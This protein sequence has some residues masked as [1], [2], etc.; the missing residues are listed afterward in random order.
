MLAGG[1]ADKAGIKAGDILLNA[2]GKPVDNPANLQE[3]LRKT[4]GDAIELLIERSGKQ[5]SIRLA[6]G[7]PGICLRR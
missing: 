7:P 6:K 2:N 3:I 4:R 5:L 1:N